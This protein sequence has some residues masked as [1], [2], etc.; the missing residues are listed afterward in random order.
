MQSI[1]VSDE[2]GGQGPFVGSV[3]N[4]SDTH[5]LRRKEPKLR[6]DS[7]GEHPVVSVKERLGK[8][9]NRGI[10]GDLG[11]SETPVIFNDVFSVKHKLEGENKLLRD[12]LEER[13]VEIRLLDAKLSDLRLQNSVLKNIK[14]HLVNDGQT[15]GFLR[16]LMATDLSLSGGTVTQC[17]EAINRV[18]ERKTIMAPHLQANQTIPGSSAQGV[19]PAVLRPFMRSVMERRYTNSDYSQNPCLPGG[20]S[21]IAPPC[22][23]R[24]AAFLAESRAGSQFVQSTG[25]PVL[26]SQDSSVEEWIMF[27]Q[28]D[29]DPSSN[30]LSSACE[31]LHNSKTALPTSHAA[32]S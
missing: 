1:P 8:D 23:Q 30:H 32:T 29:E 31:S 26:Y 16:H 12:E 27:D 18:K 19:V 21:F 20:S 7:H 9:H 3:E 25:C 2:Q 5:P 28:G 22:E 17:Q 13:R 14:Y 15:A 24:G 11:K 10:P 6:K 4:F